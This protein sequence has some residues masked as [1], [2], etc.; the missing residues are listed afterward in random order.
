M[1]TDNN[2]PNANIKK[3][4]KKSYF[5]L[6]ERFSYLWILPMLAVFLTVFLLVRAI[7][8]SGVHITIQFQSAEGLEANK[9][10]VKIRGV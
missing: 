6:R 8:Q 9:T 7:S 3:E 4:N 5:H 10:Q 1:M 2:I